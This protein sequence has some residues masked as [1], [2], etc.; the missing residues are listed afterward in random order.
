[1]RQSSMWYSLEMS[2][3]LLTS[4]IMPLM[5]CS[6]Q[7]QQE[8]QKGLSS[9][10]EDLLPSC[11]TLA[12]IWAG[13]KLTASCSSPLMPFEFSILRVDEFL[14]TFAAFSDMCITEIFPTL[15]FGGTVWN[16]CDWDRENNLFVAIRR[17]EVTVSSLRKEELQD[18]QPTLTGCLYERK[19]VTTMESGAI[20][21]CSRRNGP[22]L[23]CSTMGC[24]PR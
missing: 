14:L 13:H 9:S 11:P 15:A 23:W 19:I 10:R 4:P 12:S 18:N 17:L 6:L 7:V 24:M 1:M 8:F 22:S 2:Y 21:P 3:K 5:S 16:P 20:R